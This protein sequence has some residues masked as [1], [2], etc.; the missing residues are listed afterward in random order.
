LKVKE[1]KMRIQNNI[2]LFDDKD[3]NINN[4][5]CVF[6][7]ITENKRYNLS[8]T[9]GISGSELEDGGFY[10]ESKHYKIFGVYDEK[11]NTI[12]EFTGKLINIEDIKIVDFKLIDANE[13]I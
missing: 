8:G 2:Q 1:G 10:I 7:Y 6:H 5:P 11:S 3:I 9:Y 4:K 13:M 12:N